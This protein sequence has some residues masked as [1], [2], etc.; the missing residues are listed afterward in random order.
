[1]PAIAPAAPPFFRLPEA[2]RIEL[3]LPHVGA[4]VR[5]TV[6]ALRDAKRSADDD[7]ITGGL[8]SVARLPYN[9]T[10]TAVAVIRR[11]TSE[12]RTIRPDV[13]VEL[14][15]IAKAELA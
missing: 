9:G 1:M 13:A 7:I 8:I 10:T 4:L 6:S 12:G 11:T 15:K 14:A 5:L 2:E 3:L